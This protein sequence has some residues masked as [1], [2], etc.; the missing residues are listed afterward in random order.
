[1]AAFTLAILLIALLGCVLLMVGLSQAGNRSATAMPLR[2]VVVAIMAWIAINLNIVLSEPDE[3]AFVAMWGLPAAAAVASGATAVASA[4]INPRWR[5]SV[6]T[7]SLLSIHPTVML[8]CAIVPSWQ[9]LIYTSGDDGSIEYGPA[10]FL[11]S[12]VMVTLIVAALVRVTRARRRLPAI[13]AMRGWMVALSWFAPVI[14]AAV[15][16]S[17]S[18]PTGVDLTCAGAALAAIMLWIGALRPG[19]LEL[20]PIARDWVFDKLHDAVFVVGVDGVLVD[21]N[22]HARRL[23]E[24]SGVDATADPIIFK[25]AL[26]DFA[27]VLDAPQHDGVEVEVAGSTQ[28]FIAWVTA[29]QIERQPGVPLG[30]LVQVRDITETALHHR[31]NESMRLALI[32]ESKVNER[33]RAELSEQV[34]RDPATGLRNRR[35]VGV[36]VPAMMLRARSEGSPFSLLMVDIDHFKQINDVHGHTVGDRDGGARGGRS[37]HRRRRPCA[38]RGKAGRAGL[39]QDVGARHRRLEG[40]DAVGALDTHRT[41][42]Q[43]YPPRTA[44]KQDGT[45]E[46]PTAVLSLLAQELGRFRSCDVVRDVNNAPLHMR[47]GWGR[48]APRGDDVAGGDL[49]CVSHLH[50]HLTL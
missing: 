21:A 31:E 38:L 33:L 26:S 46:F 6:S 35:F 9:H 27:G 4:L 48:G 29:T 10:I 8:L 42:A 37:P 19:L 1:M 3:P 41:A 5:V 30:T 23:L 17:G 40:V 13:A 22:D 47:A 12:T 43:P 39:H 11:H 20:Q 28:P 2:F 32:A 50:S 34:M 44:D 36:N 45:R 15:T 7:W 14:C 18:V 16:I 49:R 24:R 25:E